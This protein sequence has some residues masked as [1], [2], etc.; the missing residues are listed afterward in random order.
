MSEDELPGWRL[1]WPGV[2][3]RTEVWEGNIAFELG[4]ITA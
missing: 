4:G 3:G 1:R 2:V